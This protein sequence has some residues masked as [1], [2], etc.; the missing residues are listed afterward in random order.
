MPPSLEARVDQTVHAVAK[1]RQRVPITAISVEHV[2]FDTQAVRNPEISGIEYQQGTLDGYAVREY[3]LE[4]RGRTCVY[5]GAIDVPLQVEHIVPKSRGGS[6]RVSNLTLACEPCNLTENNQTAIEFGYPHIQAQA[7]KPLKDAAM[8]NATRWRLYEHLKATGLPVEGGAGARTKM[9]NS[10]PLAQR[11]LLRCA[12]RREKHARDVRRDDGYVQVWSA[13]GRGN[14]QRCRTNKYGFPVAYRLQQKAHFGF[15]TGDLIRA[16][17][18]NGKYAGTHMGRVLVRSSGRFDITV[19]GRRIA[20]GISYKHC[21]ILQRNGGR[22]YEQ[23]PA[24][25]PRT[26]VRGFSRAFGH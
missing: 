5:C 4:K 22:A 14:R 6:N 26:E 8:M 18:S 11:A 19:A 20:Q 9:Q 25:L 12:L 16:A 10:T 13:K 15:Q 1:L 21:R 3:L 23:K 2:R 7:Q 24:Y 17:V